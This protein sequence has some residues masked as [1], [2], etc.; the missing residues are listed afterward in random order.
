VVANDGKSISQGL[1][2]IRLLTV[3]KL[4]CKKW[5]KLKLKI[6]IRSINPKP[7]KFIKPCWVFWVL[8]LQIQWWKIKL[9]TTLQTIMHHLICNFRS[10]L[11]TLK[12]FSYSH[13]ALRFTKKK[14]LQRDWNFCVWNWIYPKSQQVD[15]WVIVDDWHNL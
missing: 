10:I 12:A 13:F 6:K 8:C 5:K 3:E 4:Y 1:S 7:I 15:W 9:T 14:G 2:E 11:Y